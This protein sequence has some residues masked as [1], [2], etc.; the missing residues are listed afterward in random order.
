MDKYQDPD[1]DPQQW[2]RESRNLSQ[3]LITDKNAK[4]TGSVSLLPTYGHLC[5]LFNVDAAVVLDLG[6]VEHQDL[7][8]ALD[9][10]I[11]HR[12]LHTSHNTLKGT[13]S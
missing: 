10:G 11:R 12:H 4:S 8:P 5:E 3:Q 2:F 1:S 7:A 13:M 9:V 6:E